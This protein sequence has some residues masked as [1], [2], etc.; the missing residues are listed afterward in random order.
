M[1][2]N[3]ETLLA[4]IGEMNASNSTNHKIEI[5]KKYSDDEFIF[6][7][8]QYTYHP[9]KQYGV[10]SANLK[11]RSEILAPGE[12]YDNLFYLLDDLNE[13]KLTGHAAIAAANSFIQHNSK[14]A[15]FIYQVIDRNLETRATTTLINRVKPGLIPTFNVALA[16]DFTKVKNIDITDGTWFLSR[17]LDGVRCLTIV[18]DGTVRCFSRNGKEFETLGV[19]KEEI[20]RLGITDC[21]LDGEIC[22]MKEDGSDDFQGILKEIQRKDHTI[23]LPRY[24]VFDILTLEEFDSG[25][26]TVALSERRVR[27]SFDSKILVTLPQSI[28]KSAEELVY[29]RNTAKEKGWEGL[30]ARRD[31]G[32]EGDRTKN[33]LKLKEFFDAEYRVVEAIMGAQRVI[34]EEREVEE[35]VLSAVI[36]EHKGNRVQVGSGFNMDERRRYFK[37][38]EK[39]VG[40]I[41]NVQYFESTVDQHGSY[42]LRFPVF[43]G[44]YGDSRE[45]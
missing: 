18:R 35:I 28:L 5:L 6:K 24:W 21:V 40:K 34:V 12:V 9:Y 4:F 16:H 7:V 33:M 8:L 10:T 2:G 31:V 13:R 29:F 23:K 42:S 25:T 20:R 36:V 27:K 26:G 14:Y 37:N 39:I 3:F 44:V 41:I 30:I 22:V 11:K 38:P 43:K 45:I 1:T 15:D 19:V 32:Y 17:K